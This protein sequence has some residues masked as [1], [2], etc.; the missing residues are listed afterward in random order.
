[1]LT[2]TNWPSKGH[3]II[4]LKYIFFTTSCTKLYHFV[5]PKCMHS[6][7]VMPNTKYNFQVYSSQSVHYSHADSFSI[8]TWYLN[9]MNPHLHSWNPAF[10]SS[11]PSQTSQS[12]HQTLL[13]VHLKPII[14]FAHQSLTSQSKHYTLLSILLKP[15]IQFAY[16]SLTSQIIHLKSSHGFYSAYPSLTSQSKH[17]SQ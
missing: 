17:I 10:Y 6:S 8:L 4:R 2:A 15:C 3:H 1:M 11:Y 13:S 7:C 9:P 12:I 14:Q 5:V 16:Q